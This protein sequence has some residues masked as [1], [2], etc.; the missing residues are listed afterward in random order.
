MC[1]N[2]NARKSWQ[3]EER[4]GA[5]TQRLELRFETVPRGLGGSSW[6]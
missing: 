3:T 4:A 6:S 2:Y 1:G 5:K